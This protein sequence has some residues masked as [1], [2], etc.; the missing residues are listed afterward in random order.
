MESHFLP[1]KGI[2]SQVRTA[3]S[4]NS[5]TLFYTYQGMDLPTPLQS[6]RPDPRNY[7]K[8]GKLYNATIYLEKQNNV[9]GHA[10]EIIRRIIIGS[11][12][13]VKVM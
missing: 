4:P 8:S 10:V 7:L 11:K 3:G 2:L 9:R 13:F 1:N 5:H 12:V 6:Y